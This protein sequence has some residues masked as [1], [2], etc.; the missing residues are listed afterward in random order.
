MGTNIQPLFAGGQIEPFRTLERSV[1]L[2]LAHEDKMYPGAMIAS[3]NIPWGEEKGDEELGGY[4][5]VWTRDMVQA[6]LPCWQS[7]T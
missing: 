7:V 2:L 4:H 1:N 5:L 3:L 6:R